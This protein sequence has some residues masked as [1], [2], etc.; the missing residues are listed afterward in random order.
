[1]AA[2]NIITPT[3]TNGVTITV[4]AVIGF[5]VLVLIA[6]AFHWGVGAANNM[7]GS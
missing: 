7:Q 1:M 6:Q 4:M 3:I 2:E 5:T